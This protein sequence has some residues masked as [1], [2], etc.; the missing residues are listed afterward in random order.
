MS[1]LY[2]EENKHIE[3]ETVR[4]NLPSLRKPNIVY[5]GPFAY[6]DNMT[7]N[8]LL[9]GGGGDAVLLEMVCKGKMDKEYLIENYLSIQ[10]H[11]ETCFYATAVMDGHQVGTGRSTRHTTVTLSPCNALVGIVF[12][13]RITGLSTPT[14]ELELLCSRVPGLSIGPTLIDHAVNHN[15]ESN[16][17]LKAVQDPPSVI[18]LYEHK[19]FR[20]TGET[21][22][23]GQKPKLVEMILPTN[24]RGRTNKSVRL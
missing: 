3:R 24:K 17:V 22:E 7:V 18:R 15:R 11:Y 19:G 1:F 6:E 5:H 10:N 20:R 12:I 23:N 14:V 16:I 9:I 13:K 2:C 4:E 8:N 21:F